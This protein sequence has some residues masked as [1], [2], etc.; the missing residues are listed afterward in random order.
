MGHSAG[1]ITVTLKS[2][3]FTRA[4]STPKPFTANQDERKV[5]PQSSRNRKI[6]NHVQQRAPARSPLQ[7]GHKTGTA[8][9]ATSRSLRLALTR[10]R[11]RTT[12]HICIPNFPFPP[13]AC[14]STSIFRV[15]ISYTPNLPPTIPASLLRSHSTTP[16]VW[17]KIV[18]LEERLEG[19]LEYRI[20]ETALETCELRPSFSGVVEPTIKY[21]VE[22]IGQLRFCV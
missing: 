1:A 14:R 4:D 6:L 8:P 15:R 2:S 5:R 13:I 9:P 11:L 19:P 16:G 7:D 10:P 12:L 18:V 21:E 3:T 17:G 20:L 22:P